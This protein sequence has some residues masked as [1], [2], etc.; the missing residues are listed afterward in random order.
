MTEQRDCIQLDQYRLDLPHDWASTNE[1]RIDLYP[2]N[3]KKKTHADILYN[4]KSWLP[5]GVYVDREYTAEIEC[6]GKLL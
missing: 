4:S 5:K 1:E 3:S 2:F 6:Q